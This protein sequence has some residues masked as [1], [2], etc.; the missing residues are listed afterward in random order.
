MGQVQDGELLRELVVNAALA[1]G[2][3]VVASKLDAA[4]G[5][6]NVEETAGLAA[7]AVHGERLADGGLHAEETIQ[8]SAEDVVVI[9]TIDERFV[10]RSF[11]RGGAINDALVEIGGANAPDLAGEHHV[12]AVVHFGE[13][14]KGARLLGEWNDVLAAVVLYGDV[15]FFD[16]DVGVP[17]SPM[18]PSLTR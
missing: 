2:G 7:L 5:V 3:R 12:V 10:E 18:V 16:V 13:V 11:F 8:D 15:A 1:P 17:Y 9:E 4:N 14:V 6:A